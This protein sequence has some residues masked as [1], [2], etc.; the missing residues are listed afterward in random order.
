V[1]TATVISLLHGSFLTVS[2][3]WE[4]ALW[5]GVFATLSLLDEFF[6]RRRRARRL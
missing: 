2:M 4:I 6:K 5:I 1:G 3:L